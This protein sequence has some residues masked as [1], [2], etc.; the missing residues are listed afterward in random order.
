MLFSEYYQNLVADKTFNSLEVLT[1][2]FSLHFRAQEAQPPTTF[3]E[4]DAPR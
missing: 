3:V 2:S 1:A 4:S